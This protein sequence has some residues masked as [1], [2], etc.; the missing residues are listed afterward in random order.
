M[1][2]PCVFAVFGCQELAY[3]IGVWS[4]LQQAAAAEGRGCDEAL[5]P[6][7]AT[8]IVTVEM[9]NQGLTRSRATVAKACA[10]KVTRLAYGRAKVV[11]FR[12]ARSTATQNAMQR[13]QLPAP[14]S[15]YRS[16]PVAVF[17]RK[18]PDGRF[19]NYTRSPGEKARI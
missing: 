15:N 12:Q 6:L 11:A 10:T 17:D 14:A 7:R 9:K 3:R 19:T 16:R 2:S 18:K 1:M 5:M 13:Y 8:A 4:R